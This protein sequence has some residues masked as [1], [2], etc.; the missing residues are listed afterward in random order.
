MEYAPIIPISAKDGTGV[1]KILN[2]AIKMYRQLN[3][4]INTSQL[5]QALEKWLNEFPPPSGPRTRFKIKY[6]VQKSAN[7]VRF[8]FF[9][10]RTRA[11][12][13]SYI[14]YL[15]NKIRKDL[16]FSLIP[17]ILELRGTSS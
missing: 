7:P 10:S 3:T 6:A 14:S 4:Q 5:N 13:E 15:R 8:I 9:S 16:G 2:T 1:D 11:V 17:V 12:S